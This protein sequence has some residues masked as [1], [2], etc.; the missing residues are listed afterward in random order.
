MKPMISKGQKVLAAIVIVLVILIIFYL[1]V[2]LRTYRP[3]HQPIYGVTFSKKF[4][5]H[6]KLDW[7]LAYLAMLDDLQI[8]YLRLP[9]YWEEIE[10]VNDQFDFSDID[11]QLNEAH[12]RNVKV[13]LVVGRRQPRWPECHDPDWV[14]G[15]TEKEI[16]QHVLQN[17]DKVISRYSNHPA[18]EIWQVENEPFLDFFGECENKISQKELQEEIDLVRSLDNRKILIT[19]SGELGFWYPLIKMGDYFGTTL[20][21]VTYNEYIGFWEYFFV[22]PSF[23]RVKAA[24]LGSDLDRTFIAELQTEPWFP[25]G[26][27]KSTLSDHYK[28]MDATKLKN[29]VAYAEKTGF[30]RLY[31]WG[32][33]WWY[34]LKTKMND[35]SL[36]QAAKTIYQK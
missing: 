6:L 8:K 15:L 9:T 26:P 25:N 18:I 17:I 23:Y 32:V 30:A 28:T 12:K 13:I 20:Y 7:Q 22:P 36:W 19:D 33:E 10:P 1:I 21:R 29:N 16:R 14:K 5:E 11:W 31:L 27:L 34:W 2:A 4:A 35:D 24:I 3:D